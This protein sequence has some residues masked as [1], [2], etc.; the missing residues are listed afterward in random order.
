MNAIEIRL[1]P[2]FVTALLDAI[3]PALDELDEGLAA[4]GK[5]PEEDELMR[6]VWIGDLLESQREDVAAVTALFDEN[7]MQTGRAIIEPNNMDRVLRACSAIRLKLR[8]TALKD[9]GD[10][11]LEVG[12]LDDLSWSESLRVAYGAYALFATLQELIVTQAYGDGEGGEFDEG[13]EDEDD[14]PSGA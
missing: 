5:P 12:D 6:D 10:E 13:F 8:E 9:V 11:Q 3:R 2:K 7:F 1:N 14:R 4:P